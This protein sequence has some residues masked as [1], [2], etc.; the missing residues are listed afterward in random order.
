M[1]YPDW[2]HE[3]PILAAVQQAAHRAVD[4]EI[5]QSHGEENDEGGQQAPFDHMCFIG[6]EQLTGK[7]TL[8]VGSQDGQQAD[9]RIE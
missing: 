4:I 2:L 1:Q 9:Q 6:G 3:C 5:T 7:G 8:L